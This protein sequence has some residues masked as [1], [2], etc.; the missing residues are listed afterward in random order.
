[1]SRTLEGQNNQSCIGGVPMASW[2]ARAPVVAGGAT[3][4][5]QA[6]L[7][8]QPAPRRSLRRSL[9]NA[10]SGLARRMS[11]SGAALRQSLRRSIER[12]STYSTD[13][14]AASSLSSHSSMTSSM[15]F[16]SQA[17]DDWRHAHPGAPVHGFGG[18]APASP[19]QALYPARLPA[20]PAAAATRSA[21]SDANLADLAP[22]FF[23]AGASDKKAGKRTAQRQHDIASLD[24]DFF[25]SSGGGSKAKTASDLFG[26]AGSSTVGGGTRKAPVSLPHQLQQQQQQQVSGLGHASVSRG[27]VPP[28]P[29]LMAPPLGLAPVAAAGGYLAATKNGRAA[30]QL[31][32]EVTFDAP[33]RS[34]RAAPDV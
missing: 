33:D 20:P 10:V 27:Y 32:F 4:A 16:S 26:S 7:L 31:C 30:A 34:G 2:N 29:G 14:S 5:Q 22:D 11:G 18:F 17:E 19:Q 9:G 1:V 6:Q 25:P 24:P 28:P 3:L 8:A 13:S 21:P 12:G 23:D 15:S